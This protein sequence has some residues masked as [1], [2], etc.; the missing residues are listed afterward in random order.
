MKA[1]CM[2]HV[3]IRQ[4]SLIFGRNLQN[5]RCSCIS[6]PSGFTFDWYCG[7]NPFSNDEILTLSQAIWPGDELKISSGVSRS[8][9]GDELIVIVQYKGLMVISKKVETC[10][11]LTGQE[12]LTYKPR[13]KL[14]EVIF[15]ES[16][17][18]SGDKVR[19]EYQC[20][21]DCGR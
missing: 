21:K 9:V 18:G 16:R 7:L 19:S 3:Q 13:Q 17:I 20:S 4:F 10:P 8:Q 12:T 14:D 1:F 11:V 2:T 5:F 6:Q 15:E